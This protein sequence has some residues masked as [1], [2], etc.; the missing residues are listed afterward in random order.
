M[1]PS[2]RV[3]VGVLLCICAKDFSLTVFICVRVWLRLLICVCCVISECV[4][5]LF[6]AFVLNIRVVSAG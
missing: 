6:E 3:C 4:G 1:C 5:S 2:A